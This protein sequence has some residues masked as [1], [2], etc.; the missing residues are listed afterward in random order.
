VAEKTEPIE[1]IR[2][3]NEPPAAPNPY[4]EGPCY[5]DR[6]A[7][8]QFGTFGEIAVTDQI[9]V[10]L[11]RI[12][13][14]IATLR[15]EF[16]TGDVI[17]GYNGVFCSNLNTPAQYSFNAQFGKILKRNNQELGIEEI[18]ESHPGKDDRGQPTT[19]SLWRRV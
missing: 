10:N 13:S 4:P 7:Q 19:M 2:P 8:E 6:E 14:I 11:D 3:P 9:E 1:A 15:P 18:T 12:R 5:S 17:G 16:S